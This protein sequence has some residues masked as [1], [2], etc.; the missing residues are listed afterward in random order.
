MDPREAAHLVRID[1]MRMY[2]PILTFSYSTLGRLDRAPHQ[3]PHPY[4]SGGT[5]FL[6]LWEGEWWILMQGDT[7]IT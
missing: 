7:W 4:R 3:S 6:A 2:G 5:F 1:E